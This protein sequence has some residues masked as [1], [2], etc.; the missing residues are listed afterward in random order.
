MMTLGKIHNNP[1]PTDLRI[2][3]ATTLGRPYYHFSALLKSLG[4]RFDS[5]LPA[6][7]QQYDGHLLL[8]TSDESLRYVSRKPLLLFEDLFDHPPAVVCGLIIRKLGL[9][10]D[11]TDELI[12]GIDPGQRI[13]L[14][15]LY[16]GWE[17]ESSIHSS[18]DELVSH[19]IRVL[20]RLRAG[21][22]L[23][24]IGDGDMST[25]NKIVQE[26][27]L[28]FCSSFELE[29]IDER[30]T[31]LK[32]KNFNRR[33]RRDILSARCILRREGRHHSRRIV[34]LSMTG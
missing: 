3:V 4:V 2:G 11:T 15:V 1:L 6:E 18:V 32:I 26:L 34:P 8:M 30:N 14:S 23:I 20:G 28:R 9:Y 25:T 31:S 5:I 7:I 10:H 17:I 13:G 33:G 12:M 29:V 21:R 24:K 22:K 16:C 19:I 27:N